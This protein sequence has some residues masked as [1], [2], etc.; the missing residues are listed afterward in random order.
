[1]RSPGPRETAGPGF[2]YREL[3]GDISQS[4]LAIGWRTPGIDHADTPVLDLASTLLGAGR[5]SRLYRAVRE[6]KLASSVT[7]Y[8]Y[9]P[10]ELGVFVVHAE[11]EPESAA[12]AA[13]AA[14]AQVR[15][16]AAHG[17]S[18][19]EVERARR[20]YESR[21][22]RRL[23]TME[24]QAN[25]L[26]EWEAA[27]GWTR[28]DQYLERV[29][30]GS[31]AEVRA[32]T[33]RWLDPDLAS[34]VVYRP[35][36]TAPVAANAD[37]MR[38][39][40]TTGDVAPLVSSPPREESPVAHVNGV[41]ALERE[42]AR[43]RV[44]RTA[45]EVPVLVRRK[46]NATI[47]HLGVF[48]R[49]GSTDEG[50]QCAGLT[51]L[52]A[53]TA[54]KGT[55]RRG[56]TRIAEDAEFLGGSLGV[57]V[58]NE[59]FGWTISVPVRH[60]AA[61]AELLADVA[62]CPVIPDDAFETERAVALS[63]VAQLRD[64]MF[65]YP[66]RLATT[67]A[68][69]GH[70]YGSPVIGSEESLAGLSAEQARAWHR[71]HVLHA[72]TVVGVVVDADPD[73]IAAVVARHFAGLRLREPAPLVVPEWPRSVTTRIESR[74][75][76]QTALALAFPS[77]GRGDVRRYD[78]QLLAGVAS[79]LGGR[80]FDELR[81]KRSLAYTVN[82]YAN[83]R[84][85]AGT[86][87]S[88]IATSPEQEDTAREGLLAEF[89]KLRERPVSDEELDRAK[90]YAVGTHAIRQ[91]SGSAILH[92]MTDA[93]LLGGGLAELDEHDERVRA[94]TP[95]GMQALAR[96]YF[97]EDRRVEGIVRGVGKSV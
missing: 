1:M 88:Y 89:A 23:E 25:H 70:P 52:M 5:A 93:W 75:K 72:P 50:V 80:F 47:A 22:M 65:R 11:T 69:G 19:D 33:R 77:P 49:G 64:D 59:T 74:E 96:E 81:D 14:W 78:A 6:R 4:Q 34:V 2:R 26:A 20:I 85:L 60:A 43:V 17:V 63:E 53:R 56:V 71:E 31:A 97:A 83:E 87:L 84:R 90:R 13:R 44:Y 48:F 62:T 18:E 3:Q 55:A 35:A 73:R 79:G 32:V 39:L 92:D 45:H 42:V 7:A 30:A 95:T 40:L 66:V 8:N 86:F 24:G 16:V 36:A 29:L 10:T 76:A 46:P 41:P 82:A 21:W 37:A 15:D 94:V 9:V 27:G 58:G 67:A 61:A 38:R 12:D 28:A 68:F 57:S 91:E 51:V 54:L